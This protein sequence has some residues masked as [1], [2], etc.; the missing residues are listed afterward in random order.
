MKSRIGAGVVAGVVAGIVFGIIEMA[1][2][3]RLT[4]GTIVPNLNLAARTVQASSMGAAW[5]WQLFGTG[6]AG[7]IFAAIFYNKIY[8][9]R[10]AFIWGLLYGAIMWVISGLIITPVATHVPVGEIALSGLLGW[11][12][13]GLILGPTF[14]GLYRPNPVKEAVKDLGARVGMR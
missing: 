2:Q 7:A 10:G 11:L 13:Y 5:L 8:T 6:V 1:F 4:D 9:R 3:A 14:R 12:V